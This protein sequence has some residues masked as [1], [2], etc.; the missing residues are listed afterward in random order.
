MSLLGDS[1]TPPNPSGKCLCGCGENTPISKITRRSTGDIKGHP[2][3]FVKLHQS[4][5]QPDSVREKMS[6]SQKN[7]FKN[8]L[9]PNH[10]N[11]T[12]GERIVDGYVYVYA[13]DHPRTTMGKYVLRTVLVVEKALGIVIP[14]GMVIH[15]INRNKTDDRIENLAVLTQPEHARIHALMHHNFRISMR[16]SK[17]DHNSI[18]HKNKWYPTVKIGGKERHLGNCTSFEEASQILEP[19]RTL[20]YGWG[21]L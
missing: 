14:K 1:M 10:P 15:H 2:R 3:R 12:G 11:W 4:R 9:G 7:R 21:P 20:S 16:I 13:P 18:K 19:Y 6:I 5:N 17:N 8:Q